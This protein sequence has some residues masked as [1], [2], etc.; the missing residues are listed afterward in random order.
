MAPALKFYRLLQSYEEL[1]RLETFALTQDNL[2]YLN[3]LQARKGPLATKL[4]SMRQVAGFS[5]SES[6]RVDE[7][8]QILEAQERQNLETLEMA[9]QTVTE[10]L[11]GLNRSQ[12]RCGRLHRSYS[13]TQGSGVVVSRSV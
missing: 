9:M 1:T 2:S 8:L 11:A 10:S 5:E 6:R 3:R 12:N 13:Q 7:R 4:A